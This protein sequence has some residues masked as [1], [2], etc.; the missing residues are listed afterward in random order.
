MFRKRDASDWQG[1]LSSGEYVPLDRIPHE[2]MAQNL[3]CALAHIS[4]MEAAAIKFANVTMA[5]SR[6]IHGAKPEFVARPALSNPSKSQYRYVPSEFR[7]ALENGVYASVDKLDSAAL[8]EHT[9]RAFAACELIDRACG[10]VDNGE[11]TRDNWSY[12]RPAPTMTAV[13]EVSIRRGREMD[14]VSDREAVMIHQRFEVMR[15]E[16]KLSVLKAIGFY[17]DFTPELRTENDARG[18]FGLAWRDVVTMGIERV[19]EEEMGRIAV[20]DFWKKNSV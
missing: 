14:K 5:L 8:I 20:S 16:D 9:V 18:V 17:D 7:V 10:R 4:R 11:S 15:T 13:L 19:L 12:S 6:A 1:A 3:C 2:Q